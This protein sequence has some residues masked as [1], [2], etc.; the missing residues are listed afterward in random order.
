MKFLTQ[1][2]NGLPEYG[3]LKSYVQKKAL[4]AA[5]TGVSGIH[6][7][8]II[9][10][11]C[12]QLGR[13]AFVVAG[14][15]AEA[16]R[17]C[18]D[19]K[20]MGLSP[21]FYPLRDFS[22]H[23]TEGSSH[24]YEHQRLAVLR[25]V[26]NGKCN[27]VVCC[28]DAAL[29]YTIPPDEMEKHTVT[30]KTGEGIGMENA[31]TALLQGGYEDAPQI[32][33]A[34]QFS[35]R[36]GI[37]DFYPPGL[38]QPVRAEFFGDEIDTLSFFDPVSQRRTDSTESVTVFPASEVL[39]AKP[40]ITAKK[41]D[42]LASQLRGK[43]A[44]A[45]KA[46]LARESAKLREGLHIGCADK[47]ISLVYDRPAS[48]FDYFADDMVL[49]VNEPVKSKERMKSVVWQWGEDVRDLLADGTLCRG[50]SSFTYD[51]AYAAE[52]FSKYGAVYL[53]DFV[54]GGYDT[55]VM[56][57]V[58]MT[59]RQG[60]AW[61]GNI[62]LLADDL[63][64]ML[65]KKWSC[66]VL[67]G[68]ER[69]ART[70]A[71]DLLARG[72]NAFYSEDP[73]TI[74]RGQVAVIPG[75]L[76]GGIE[77]PG[78]FF[79]LITRG[80]TAE[81]RRGKSKRPKNAKEITGI[82]DLNPGDY[83]VHTTHGIGVFEGIRKIE[84]HGVTKDYITVKYAKGDVLYVPVT[85]LDMVS[86]YIGPREDSSVRLSRL[87]GADWQKAK[88]KVRRA[89]KDIA[90]DLIKLYAQRMNIKGCAFPADDDLQRDFESR[91]E[92]DETDDQLRCIEEIKADMEKSVP[93]DRLLCGDVGFGKT[94]VALRAA[95]KCVEG[96]KQCAMLVPTTLLAWQH[97]QTITRRFE[98]F[99]V[100]VELLSR[101]RS[102]KE[103]AEV[104]RKCKNGEI[105]I[106][107]GTHRIISND[108]EF[109]DLGLIIIDEEQRFGVAQKEKLKTKYKNVDV[110]TLSA[111]PI[112]RTL[113][114][115]MSGMRDMSIIEEAPHDRHPVQTYV[116]EHDDGII[117]DAIRQELRR[118]GQVYYLHND[119]ASIERT[120][121]R[122]QQRVPEAK[123][124]FGH[125]KMDEQE[126]SEAWRK[127]I[128]QEINVFVCT[129]I[130]ETGVD[131]PNVNTLIID[132]ADRMGLSQLHQIRGRVGRSSRRAYAYLTFARDKVLSEIS[133]KRLSAIR[134]FTEFGSGFKIAMRDLEI[135][136]AGNILGGEQH[137][138]MEAVGYDMY[139]R[140]LSEAIGKAKGEPVKESGGE[141]TVDVQVTAHIPES[142]ISDLNQRLEIYRRIADIRT[143]ADASDVTDELI[144]RFGEP[145]ESVGGLVKIAL[146][147]SKASQAGF[148]EIK[149][150]KD[151]L[152]MY[153]D[154]IDMRRVSLLT[155]A[156]HGRVMLSAGAKP[157][158]SVRMGHDCAPIE[159]LSEIF[160]ALDAPHS[161]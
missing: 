40:D 83:I 12:S 46:V 30:I 37:L 104:I 2:V 55:P 29:Q 122:I 140:L 149:Q 19:L 52:C 89:V 154:A 53:D 153:V 96:S 24:E 127:L 5:V 79:G 42:R 20:A 115:A 148:T 88:A 14:D 44:P 38:S 36:G 112:P 11:L 58:N 141:C 117:A 106:I 107:V 49:F 65:E 63:S 34:G 67:A 27:A 71:E 23:D 108:V 1:A 3:A 139:L 41:I 35:R 99:P 4:P 95:F 152:L 78:A 25:N 47:Y 85:Q 51:Y 105:D 125:G 84:M 100:K 61:G 134:Q 22:L 54:H 32:D 56:G 146:L 77:Y 87:G 80:R 94:E 31:V 150:Q 93:M 158:I 70:T 62:G 160:N 6:K 60:S 102:T 119:V 72:I 110:L 128:E 103:Q 39:I 90:N 45:A 101:F 156:L 138:H 68:T 16:N 155:S 98:G 8:N 75:S 121:A 57:Q 118:G 147:R 142:Y 28:I 26:K 69:S 74:K 9:Y 91:F 13:R 130:I 10:S 120:A 7:A 33:G 144:D 123:V 109:R 92:F 145:P 129:T 126:L 73:E 48:L 64:G 124:G 59:A 111:T 133:Q 161:A 18:L 114:M 66:A 15:E 113:N 116:L 81:A 17:L 157:Y 132:N 43:T 131:V 82:S 76:S 159:T 151:T 137:G 136:G 97:Y 21:M 143:D 50:L 86:K 135:R